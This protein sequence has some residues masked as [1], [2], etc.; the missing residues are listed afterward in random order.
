MLTILPSP[1]LNTEA[2]TPTSTGLGWTLPGGSSSC[3]HPRRKDKAWVDTEMGLKKAVRVDTLDNLLVANGH[4]A[5]RIFYLKVDIEGTEL[6][7]LPGWVESG[8]LANVDQLAL[9]LH[10]NTVH[11]ERRWELSRQTVAPTTDTSGSTGFC[12]CSSTC[13]CW[14]LGWYRMR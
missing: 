13:T 5:R 14:A 12:R 8:V 9:E 10:L 11:E 6:R 2:A 3:L 1:S 4:R 7:A